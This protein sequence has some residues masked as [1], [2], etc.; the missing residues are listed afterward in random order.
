MLAYNKIAFFSFSFSNIF[1][2]ISKV[3]ASKE[4]SAIIN[5]G[6]IVSKNE[7]YSAKVLLTPQRKKEKIRM[8]VVEEKIWTFSET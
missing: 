1:L 3:S 8:P 5:G 7:K 2:I 4:N 6:D